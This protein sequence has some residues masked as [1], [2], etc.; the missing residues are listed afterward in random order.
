MANFDSIT[1]YQTDISDI[2]NIKIGIKQWKLIFLMV[3]LNFATIIP[4]LNYLMLLVQIYFFYYFY[5]KK[6]Y[7]YFALLIFNFSTYGRGI[8]IYSFKL[9]Y[10]LIFSLFL[11]YKNLLVF[12]INKSYRIY[13][14]ISFL[15]LFLA[16]SC[17]NL[18]YSFNHFVSDF[19]II[20]GFLFGFLLFKNLHQNEL[21]ELSIMILLVE[22]ITSYITIF[23]GLG[24]SNEID[25]FG[26]RSSLIGNS[27]GFS[28]F[29]FFCIY[30]LFFLKKCFFKK[31]FILGSYLYT[32]IK[33]SAFGS[34]IMLFFMFCFI[35]I[36][37]ERYSFASFQ[38]KV[39][40]LLF[41]P[42]LVLCV[43]GM[44]SF[45]SNA[46]S[47][48]SREDNKF[49]YKVQNISKL[50]KYLDFTDKEKIF[51]IPLS[52]RVRVLEIANILKTG[53]FLSN[54]IGRG[55]G[56][57]FR[58]D[59]IHFENHDK[60]HFLGDDDFSKEER[61]S[62]NFFTAHN[63]GYPLLKYGCMFFLIAFVF[64]Y[65][66]IKKNRYIKNH[67]GIYF[68]FIV[69]LATI[70]YFGFTFQT[71]LIIG[72]LWAIAFQNKTYKVE[73]K[74]IEIHRPID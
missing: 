46:N 66:N 25:M 70:S 22:L 11:F 2:N 34:M 26:N 49:L 7:V 39:Y 19:I 71:S 55:I 60:F 61:E 9:I 18:Y 52:P 72:L 31:L 74:K 12:K 21:L 6:Q 15:F 73:E 3:F 28:I 56:S 41:I 45:I 59:F 53:N 62:H 68:Y 14:L 33:L 5:N 48:D 13:I 35:F 17:Y 43:V 47:M 4:G 58:D 57:Y 67:F 37:I 63:W 36:L 51:M 69:F 1:K 30:L 42:L 27:E 38:K 8:S 24:L 10:L 54:T 20:F 32:S 23:T 44:K 50:V 65:F 64:A 40:S 29:V 16:Y